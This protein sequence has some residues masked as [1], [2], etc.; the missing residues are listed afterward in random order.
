LSLQVRELIGSRHRV[1]YVPIT[2]YLSDPSEDA[3]SAATRRMVRHLRSDSPLTWEKVL[4]DQTDRQP[5]V[6]VAPSGSGK[7][8]ELEHQAMRL[9]QAARAAVFGSAG[10]I[11]DG[12]A[13]GLSR[14]DALEYRAWANR[15]DPLV[16]F[17]DAIDELYL[18]SRQAS[19]L[20]R[21]L[22]REI[23]LPARPIRF[24]FSARTGSWTDAFTRELKEVLGDTPQC[25]PR[26]LTIEPID[27]DALRQL[28]AANGV[29]DVDAFCTAFEAEEI[30]DLLELRPADVA[31]LAHEWNANSSLGGW[32]QTLA[33]FVTSSFSEARPERSR[34]RLLTPDVGRRGLERIAAAMTLMNARHVSSVRVS[35]QSGAISARRLFDDWTLGQVEELF[36]NPLVVPKGPNGEAVQLPPGPVFHFLAAQWFSARVRGGWSVD[37]LESVFLVRVFQEDTPHLPASLR[38]VAGWASSEISPLRRLLLKTHPDVVLYGGDPDFLAD[39]EIADGLGLL[40]DAISRLGHDP[41]WPSAGT[42]RKLARPSIEEMVRSLLAKYADADPIQLL[43][44]RLVELGRY[45]SCLS[46]ARQI[47]STTGRLSAVRA[48]AISAIAATGGDADRRGLLDFLGE[49]DEGVRVALLRSVVP[50][51]VRGPDLSRFL[52]AGGGPA[53]GHTLGRVAARL[54]TSDLD[55][56]LQELQPRLVGDT[57]S[58]DTQHAF[59]VAVQVAIARLTRPGGVPDVLLEVLVAVERLQEDHH[60][61]YL[62]SENRTAID[63]AVSRDDGIRRGLWLCRLKVA[64]TD[65]HLYLRPAFGDATDADIDW[66]VEQG[67]TIPVALQVVARVWTPST[68]SAASTEKATA[69]LFDLARRRTEHEERLKV[70]EDEVRRREEETRLEN[71]RQ[72]EQQRA[73]IESAENLGAL[74]WAWNNLRD[75][76]ADESNLDPVRLRS[77]VGPDQIEVLLRGIKASW[78]KHAVPDL[79]PGSTISV[80]AAVALTGVALD[81]RAGLDLGT[82]SPGDAERAA[83]CAMHALNHLPFWFGDLFAAHPDVVRGVL[84]KAIASEWSWIDEGH[85]ILRLAGTSSAEV[86][87]AIRDTVLEL[88]KASPPR[89]RVTDRYAVGIL[90]VSPESRES[91][92]V[93][94]KREIAKHVGSPD[95]LSEWLRLWTH[96]EP[97]RAAAWFVERLRLARA[98]TETVLLETVSLLEKDLDERFGRLAPSWLMAPESLAQWIR[99]LFDEFPPEGDVKHAGRSMHAVGSRDYAEEF[100]NRCVDR[101][102]GNTSMQAHLVLKDLLRDRALTTHYELLTRALEKQIANAVEAA[103]QTWSEEHVVST[104]RGDECRPRTLADLDV[105]VRRHLVDVGRLVMNDD[106]SYRRLFLPD[107]A[108]REI[109]LWVAS[110]L[111]TRARGSYGIVRENVV[112]LDKEVDISAHVAGVGTIPIEIKPLG[113]YSVTK[114]VNTIDQQLL[115]RYMSP[116]D[117]QFG[118]LLLVRRERLRWRHGG[119]SVELGRVVELLREHSQKVAASTGKTITVALIDLLATGDSRYRPTSQAK[120]GRHTRVVPGGIAASRPQSKKKRSGTPL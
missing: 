23:D 110:C 104:E 109:Q 81:V 93:A 39:A 12:I 50:D 69:Y 76:G 71:N 31:I 29:R 51:L 21:R 98:E 64:A 100:R 34:A 112:D 1:E 56:V 4:D 90:L 40:S 19:D 89:H 30:D 45:R 117:R 16:F 102:A 63:L 18:R 80:T 61:F 25:I 43:L 77:H 60:D 105:L 22:Q 91:V 120:P 96:F 54:Q 72:V 10:S 3:T 99:L 94:A 46:N 87:L 116:P 44:L 79:A 70:A 66:L 107:T 20:F 47:A 58:A 13:D 73:S 118:V 86:A 113:P 6:L 37:D 27:D 9:R 52:T 75:L 26:I 17:I 38:E 78:R 114:L 2:R 115:R 57:I 7:S 59:E 53:F 97:E 83:R 35:T 108:E 42:L 14:T 55:T 95:R 101:M 41:Y 119:R 82:L 65:R 88:L 28:A 48:A 68:T 85:G 15:A 32:S 33:N 106:F 92:S 111:R 49:S 74:V 24:V 5:V 62:S 84:Q 103:R 11:V 8:T 67:Q 36:E